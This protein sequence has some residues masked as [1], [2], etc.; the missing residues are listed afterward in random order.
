[1][2]P[3]NLPLVFR[4]GFGFHAAFVILALLVFKPLAAEEVPHFIEGSTTIEA[5]ALIDLVLEKEDLV[6]IDSRIEADLNEG[7][8][9]GAVNLPNISTNC[10]SLGSIIS[11][12]RTPV[13]FYCNGVKCKRSSE[14]VRIALACGYT[15]LHWFR[16][17]IEEWKNRQYPIV[18]PD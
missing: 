18:Q 9:E 11:T 15:N 5:Q 1:M 7:Y 13:A 16:G 8:I 6:I 4:R 14:A 17:G 2:A 12:H 3:N 10:E